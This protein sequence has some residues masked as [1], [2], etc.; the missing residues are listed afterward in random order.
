MRDEFMLRRYSALVRKRGGSPWLTSTRT[1][2]ENFLAL[3]I[4]NIP[5]IAESEDVML[6]MSSE[7]AIILKFVAPLILNLCDTC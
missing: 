4:L 5:D 6:E 7:E 1:A 3:P 2:N